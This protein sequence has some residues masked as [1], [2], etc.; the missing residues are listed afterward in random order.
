MNLIAQ[1]ICHWQLD[2]RGIAWSRQLERVVVLT[3]LE[4][5]N[6]TKFVFLETPHAVWLL[7]AGA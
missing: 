6:E 3:D 7:I 4:R 5:V 2:T 1:T